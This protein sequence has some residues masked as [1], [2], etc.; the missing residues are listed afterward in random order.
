[1]A[2]ASRPS[3][4]HE[5]SAM[6]YHALAAAGMAAA[7]R[8]SGGHELSAMVYHASPATLAACRWISRAPHR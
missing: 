4:G 1:M 6:V 3:G 5:L 2:A 7:S 8:P